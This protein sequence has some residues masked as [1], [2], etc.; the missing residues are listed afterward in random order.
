MTCF[1]FPPVS[2]AALLEEVAVP[3]H[4]LPY[5][6]HWNPHGPTPCI[7][8]ALPSQPCLEA[9]T[10]SGGCR[11]ALP[12]WE[13]ASPSPFSTPPPSTPSTSTTFTR[14]APPTSPSPPP[15]PPPSPTPVHPFFSPPTFAFPNLGTCKVGRR[16]AGRASRTPARAPAP[17]RLSRPTSG[18]PTKVQPLS[19]CPTYG[20]HHHQRS[21]SR[22]RDA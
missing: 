1:P 10:G 9:W 8:P 11:R 13:G 5:F 19:P 4:H 21:Q 16:R 20:P 18:P 17:R 12:S 7:R 6:A 22:G 15:P 14:P 3:H 2:Q